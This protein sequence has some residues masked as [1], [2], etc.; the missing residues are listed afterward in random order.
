MMWVTREQ[1]NA[2]KMG[3]QLL[4]RWNIFFRWN[5]RFVCHVMCLLPPYTFQSHT[6][7]FWTHTHSTCVYIYVPIHF[8]MAVPSSS[9]TVGCFLATCKYYNIWK[10]KDAKCK[11][12]KCTVS[13]V[14]VCVCVLVW[15]KIVIPNIPIFWFSG[16]YGNFSIL[17]H[18]F[19]HDGL[20]N[21]HSEDRQLWYIL[22]IKPTRC[23]NF[24]NLFLE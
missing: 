1:Y 2:W 8:S 3:W 21:L 24:S 19:A 15:L 6:K 4:V 17:L 14:C 5:K 10:F 20:F 22:I 16:R 12:Y 18:T 9:M 7:F 11:L 23:T 13:F